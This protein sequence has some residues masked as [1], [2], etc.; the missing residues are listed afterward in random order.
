MLKS[1]SIYDNL[2]GLFV[3]DILS[4]VAN[5]D[6]FSWSFVKTEGNQVV[7]ALAHR[8]LLCLDGQLW[9]SNFLEDVSYKASNDMYHYL[10]NTALI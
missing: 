5:F 3:K 6:F 4:F 8:H 9:T 7:H 1:K 2:V 10:A